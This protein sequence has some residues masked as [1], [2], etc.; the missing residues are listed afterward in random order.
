MFKHLI[1]PK[2]ELFS[3]ISQCLC[4]SVCDCFFLPLEHCQNLS[5]P[6]S[7]LCWHFIHSLIALTISFFLEDLYSQKQTPSNFLLFPFVKTNK[8][9]NKKLNKL[10]LWGCF[11]LNLPSTKLQSSHVTKTITH[12]FLIFI[13]LFLLPVQVPSLSCCRINNFLFWFFYI[14]P[15]NV[16]GFLHYLGG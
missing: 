4:I 9:A 8:Q 13:L 10:K 14:K 1:F 15:K 3:L 5:L 16:K 7:C 11:L 12:S 2:P 6:W